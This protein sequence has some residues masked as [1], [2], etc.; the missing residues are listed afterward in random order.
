MSS[1]SEVNEEVAVN[2]S[3][4]NAKPSQSY[5]S[6]EES[7]M[8]LLGK[9]KDKDTNVDCGR[10]HDLPSV[11]IPLESNDKLSETNEIVRMSIEKESE[12]EEVIFEDDSDNKENMLQ[13]KKFEDMN[14]DELKIEFSKRNM[15]VGRIK[16][17]ATFILKLQQYEAGMKK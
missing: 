1:I 14:E 9:K 17:K 15:K 2:L 5:E 7:L 6:E 12:N 3:V 8:I 16:K 10:S 4:E 11:D 13:S